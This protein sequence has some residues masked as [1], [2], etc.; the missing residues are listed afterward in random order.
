MDTQG[1]KVIQ[2]FHSSEQQEK[3]L[4]QWW[5]E[6]GFT[7]VLYYDTDERVVWAMFRNTIALFYK[8]K[9]GA[10]IILLM[11]CSFTCEQAWPL[12]CVLS[13]S[14]SFPSYRRKA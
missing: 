10:K 9:G 4:V 1:F 12:N 7:A 13:S 8:A 3:S 5:A 2:K 14:W 6:D 11:A